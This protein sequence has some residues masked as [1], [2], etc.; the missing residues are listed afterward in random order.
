MT[1]TAPAPERLEV[2]ISRLGDLVGL[3]KPSAQHKRDGHIATMSLGADFGDIRMGDLASLFRNPSHPQRQMVDVTC[4]GLPTG[5]STRGPCKWGARFQCMEY[6]SSVTICDDCSAANKDAWAI[7]DAKKRWESVCPVG[8][9][10]TDKKH[11]GFPRAQYDQLKSWT[12]Q[13]SL[14]FYGGTGKGKTRLAMLMVKRAL[15]KGYGV[16]VLWPEKIRSL[17]QG[18]DSS[19]FD[20][21]SDIPVLLM[22]DSLITACRESKLVDAVKTLLD[23]RM[24]GKKT[25]IF[26]SQIG[27][28]EEIA[29]GKEFGDAKAA[30]L[31]RIKAI[32]RR[33]R[34]SCTIVSF[35][36]VTANAGE[37]QF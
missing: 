1:D 22:D 19:F 30:D 10:D 7:A 18:Y 2:Q 37:E 25:T 14:F 20:T 33:L 13:G 3:F 12:G 26:T 16:G 34:E 24:R 9:R 27:T 28:E 31:E 11:A 4:P 8:Y 29:G 36:T 23:V 6:F 32:V 35:G 17:V 5:D 21:Y 15:L